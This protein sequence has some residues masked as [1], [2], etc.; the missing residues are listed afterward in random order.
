MKQEEITHLANLARIQLTET[1]SVDLATSITE[2]LGYVSAV[3]DIAATEK[4]KKARGLYNI[5]RDD[6]PTHAPG[7]FTDRVLDAAPHR[8]GRYVQVK[9]ILGE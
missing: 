1:E 3:N 4:E 6:E 2:I 7:E 5:M 9:K 8:D